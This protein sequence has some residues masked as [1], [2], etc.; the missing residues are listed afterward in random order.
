MPGLWTYQRYKQSC[1]CIRVFTVKKEK[2]VQQSS[3]NWYWRSKQEAATPSSSSLW[4]YQEKMSLD[5]KW[6]LIFFRSGCSFWLDSFETLTRS[7][8][9]R[10]SS[11]IGIPL[12]TMFLL[13]LTLMMFVYWYGNLDIQVFWFLK[14][15]RCM[16]W[17]S[18]A[19]WRFLCGHCGMWVYSFPLLHG[20]LTQPMTLWISVPFSPQSPLFC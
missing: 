11:N 3:L 2:F 5:N 8:I 6:V 13:N 14:A 4:N 15:N 20:S 16:V 18:G 7:I 10:V 9:L 17:K 19:L 1:A 12:W